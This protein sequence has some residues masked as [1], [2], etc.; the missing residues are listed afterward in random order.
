MC[1]H[2]LTS[3][4]I[5]V[6]E[7]DDDDDERPTRPADPRVNVLLHQYAALEKHVRNIQSKLL[8]CRQDTR[9]NQSLERIGDRLNMIEQDMT[10]MLTQWEETT[11]A[12]RKLSSASQSLPSPPSSPAGSNNSSNKPF[13]RRSMLT[14][15]AV[16]CFL[17]NKRTREKV[18]YQE[19]S[20][21]CEC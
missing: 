20:R 7:D 21:R 10:Q 18:K 8:L 19:R 9:C 11:E 2:G 15:A 5:E 17:E 1:I 3:V 14:A 12:Y 4:I 16:A 13:M 6:Y